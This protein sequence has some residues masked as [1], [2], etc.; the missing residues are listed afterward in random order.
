MKTQFPLVIE[1]TEIN[2]FVNQIQFINFDILQ[3]QNQTETFCTLWLEVDGIVDL[4]SI[5]TLGRRYQSI[6]ELNKC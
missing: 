2:Q 1:K 4:G 3:I 5:F 6:K